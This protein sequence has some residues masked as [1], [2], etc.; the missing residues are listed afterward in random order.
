[1]KLLL[2]G[3]PG[4]GKTAF[5]HLM[6]NYDPPRRHHST[7]IAARPIQAIEKVASHDGGKVWA[8]V[9]GKEMMKMLADVMNAVTEL[10]DANKK[11]HSASPIQEDKV[12]PDKEQN[13][14]KREDE[15][16]DIYEK[17]DE[18]KQEMCDEGNKLDKV[19]R[20]GSELGKEEAEEGDGGKK[21]VENQK[22]D[23][24][25]KEHKEDEGI[26]EDKSKRE[27]RQGDESKKYLAFISLSF[28][29]AFISFF[30]IFFHVISLS[31]FFISITF[32]LILFKDEREE[33]GKDPD[34]KE[35]RQ[36]KNKYEEGNKKKGEERQE[37]EGKEQEEIGD[38]SQDNTHNDIIEFVQKQENGSNLDIENT[39]K[40]DMEHSLSIQQTMSN[41]VQ[42]I[43][44]LLSCRQ[45]SN[46][47]ENASWIYIVDSGGQP[48]FLDVKRI[49]LRGCTI[50]VIL[51]KL[52]ERLSDKPKFTYSVHGKQ[53]SQPSELQLTN[54]QII[55]SLV[56]SI[57]S[58]KQVIK[59]GNEVLPI[60]PLFLIVGTHYDKTGG[61]WRLFQ[62]T[63]AHKNSQLKEVLAKFKKHILYYD[64]SNEQI[65]F[66]INN[67]ATKNRKQLS[68]QIQ[69]YI[70]TQK[71]AQLKYKLPIRWYMFEAHIKDEGSKEEHGMV[72]MAR[73]V[74]IGA[75]LGM[76]KEEVHQCAVYLQYLTT[77]LYFP[78]AIPNV[79]FT[80][81]QYL[82]DMVSTLISVSFVKYSHT[83]KEGYSLPPDAHRRLRQE[84]LFDRDLLQRIKFDFV[85]EVFMEEH[86]LALLTHLCIASPVLHDSYFMPCVLPATQLSKWDKAK[87][88]K[89]CDPL[90]VLFRSG[91]IPQ[92]CTTIYLYMMFIY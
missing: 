81:P 88:C 62:E 46:L 61:I 23:K 86:F 39:S 64:E 63:L 34:K 50:N 45:M 69:Q 68:N 20:Q 4:V 40:A 87:F 84:G 44:G 67:M 76:D 26:Q 89:T 1:M 78:E 33:Q 29:V 13:E 83:L 80:N 6:F 19:A 10:D 49:F 60:F 79:L 9:N 22:E 57:V 66:P 73:C 35:G 54:V 5:K 71:K 30:F 7:P 11:S 15:P 43:L 25:N 56:R 21:D 58:A 31:F 91:V 8:T 47:L 75:D 65:I 28:I 82:L 38:R 2:C 74:E 17:Q 14:S 90:L 92:V 36:A 52:T 41:F 42:S 77:F 3:P 24:S 70:T 18:E 16:Q 59:V 72:T 55:E 51:F 12:K 27:E 37:E 48:Q 53:V 32:F 85:F